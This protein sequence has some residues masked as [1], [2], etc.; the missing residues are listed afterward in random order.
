MTESEEASLAPLMDKVSELLNGL[1]LHQ[2][3]FIAL[4]ILTAN[5]QA[6]Y[7]ADKG[8]EAPTLQELLDWHLDQCAVQ[9]N[10]PPPEGMQ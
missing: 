6:V 1:P 5:A 10:A 7:H 3:T 2:A 8:K 9:P 4:R